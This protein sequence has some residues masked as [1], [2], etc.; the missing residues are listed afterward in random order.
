MMSEVQPATPKDEVK[1]MMRAAAA[2]LTKTLKDKVFAVSDLSF[3]QNTFQ[4]YAASMIV[5][6]CLNARRVG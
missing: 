1:I 4:D 2:L 3:Y 5:C 6:N